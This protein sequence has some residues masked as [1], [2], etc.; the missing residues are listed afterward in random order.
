MNVSRLP[1]I[2]F[3][4]AILL[5]PG[6]R[7]TKWHVKKA[8]KE[9][10]SII[11]QYQQEALGKTGKFTIE[12]PSDSLRKRLMIEQDLPGY[13][14]VASSNK[15]SGA[16]KPLQIKLLDALQIGARH[17]RN[18]QSRK[19]DVF[20][21]ALDLDL[22]R[23][24]FRNSYSGL[25]SAML[26]GDEGGESASRSVGGEASAGVTRK[27]QTGVSFAGK[28]GIDLVKLLT[29]DKTSTLGMLADATISVP[30]LRGAGRDIVREPLTQA[31]RDVIYAMWSFERFKRSFAVR[32]A[33][34][35]FGALE[36]AKQ[37]QNAEANLKSLTDARQRMQE[38][39]KAGRQP[40]TQVDQAR[41]DEL[42]ANSRLIAARQLYEASL[43]SLKM[44]IGIPVDAKIELDKEEL[45]RL[46]ET[47]AGTFSDKVAIA[48]DGAKKTEEAVLKA[49]KNRLD[50]RAAYWA[51]EDTQ[52]KLNVARDALD[53]EMKLKLSASTRDTHTSGLSETK[54]DVKFGDVKYGAVLDV[55]L[56]WDRTAERVA[57]RKSMIALEAMARQVEEQEDSIKQEI[58]SAV[59][60]LIELEET[61]RIQ[62]QAVE[63]AE[64]R[65]NST[66]IFLQ[67]GR[68]QIRDVLEAQEDL[69]SARDALVSAIVSYHMAS[70]GLQRDLE[71]LEINEEGMWASHE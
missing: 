59:R 32:M 55:G 36:Q 58:R 45:T 16:G 7:S 42:R 49:L 51:L 21:T 31:E 9:A 33:G 40:E 52:R 44:S 28:L 22:S 56:P 2:S 57:F 37:I 24:E 50:L 63:L 53:A 26:S 20:R 4:L 65:V 41:Q 14:N 25:L 43:D 34:E 1:V 15:M 61:Y 39:A 30:L 35:Y 5:L 6:C 17:N 23:A 27:F 70:L 71:L 47:T 3:I 8:D 67:A 10:G 48:E 68:S 69:V 13:G 38:L 62:R 19:E 12:R 60:K 29:M 46:S 64:R 66:E 18:Y 54:T 11:T